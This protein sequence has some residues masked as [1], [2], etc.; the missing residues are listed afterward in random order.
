M[1]VATVITEGFGTFGNN[2]FVITEGFGD[3]GGVAPPLPIP[4]PSGGGVRL[5]DERYGWEAYLERLERER[6]QILLNKIK[7]IVK[8]NQSVPDLKVKK[9]FI[10][11]D[12][13]LKLSLKEQKLISEIA[14]WQ[15]LEYELK[16]K[17]AWNIYLEDEALAILLL[18][19]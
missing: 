17:Q 11:S 10:Q 3:F 18:M 8:E 2:N 12:D 4:A 15:R 16:L 13:F 9:D 14:I 7:E 6:E 5:E 1:S 19:H